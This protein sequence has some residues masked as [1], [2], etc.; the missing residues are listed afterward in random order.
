MVILYQDRGNSGY[1]TAIVGTVS[2]TS[3][4]FGSAVVFESANSGHISAAYDVNAGKVVVS[5]ID[6]GNSSYGTSIVGTVSGTSI[7]FGSAVVFNSGTV[8][9]TNAV[10]VTYEQKIYI[11]Y[12][13]SSNSGH[14][15]GIVGT[16][17]GTSI[18]F[19]SET[20]FNTSSTNYLQSTYGG[21]SNVVT[22]YQDGGNSDYATAVV[23]TI[24]GTSVSFGTEVVVKAVSSQGLGAAYNS[25]SGVVLLTYK[26]TSNNKGLANVGTIS[27]TSISFG[28]DIEFL[29]AQPDSSAEQGSN[30]TYD[31]TAKRFVIAFSQS[32]SYAGK[33]SYIIPA[34]QT[35]PTS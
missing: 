28:S 21:G 1:G 23:G 8:S 24:S 18:S 11:A 7:S 5:Y 30:V 27:G 12:R 29:N 3:I 33:R 26:D 19:G 15:T 34:P 10:Y 35:L 20:V 14:G 16:V 13:D 2:G 9:Y 17:S 25:D 22:L 6:Y 4:S 31:T 32:G